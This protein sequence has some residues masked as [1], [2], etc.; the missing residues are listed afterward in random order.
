MPERRPGH[1]EPG[2]EQ[3]DRGVLE[4]VGARQ[5]GV[6][7]NSYIG[8]GNAGLV[9]GAQRALA[10]HG[11][12]V[13]SR[14]RLVDQKPTHVAAVVAGPDHGHIADRTV[15]DPL[16]LA[17]D[18]PFIAVTVG[19][20]L[21][22]HR[23]R[24]VVGFGQGEGAEFLGPGQR[25]QPGG[26]LLVAAEHGDAAQGESALHGHDGAHRT[27]TAGDL[28]V[29]QAGGERRHRGEAGAFD[30]VGEQVE[31]TEATSQVQRIFRLIPG[32]SQLVDRLDRKGTRPAPEGPI[33]AWNIGEDAVVVCIEWGGDIEMR[34]HYLSPQ[35][36]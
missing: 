21:E 6:K 35:R 22:G 17:V 15:A 5:Y 20:G 2:R 33:G 8:Q 29:H 31:L 11:L 14:Q 24:A 36:V 7:R 18:D 34:H 32:L 12:A 19:G 27:V 23:V 16:L 30:A 4:S 1:A 13:V 26:F 3:H 9:H 10:R 28:H 25:H